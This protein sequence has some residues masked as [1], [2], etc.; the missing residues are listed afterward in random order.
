[1]TFTPLSS[2]PSFGVGEMVLNIRISVRIFDFLEKS[3]G[4]VPT[5]IGSQA[6]PKEL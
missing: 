6:G 4:F 3:P 2:D 1:M 5:D